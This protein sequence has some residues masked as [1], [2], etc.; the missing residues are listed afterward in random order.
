MTAAIDRVAAANLA[1][2]A[3]TKSRTVE[4]YKDVRMM[5]VKSKINE[6]KKEVKLKGS[7]IKG[8]PSFVD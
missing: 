8:R 7:K 1:E 4:V 6:I 3:I 2:A 5:E